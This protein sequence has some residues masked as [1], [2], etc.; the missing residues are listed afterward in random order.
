[1]GEVM[2]IIS[3]NCGS[4]SLKISLFDMTTYQVIV[5]FNFERI[6]ISNPFYTINMNNEKIKKEKNFNNHE[7]A[8]SI[9]LTELMGL[10]VLNSL[11]EIEGVGHRVVHGGDKYNNSII[12]DEKVLADIEKYIFLAP[13]HNPSNL[14]GIKAFKKFLPNIKSVAVFDT[15]FHQTLE[16]DAYLYPVPYEWYKEYGVRKYGFHGISHKYI[17]ERMIDITGNKDLK[18]ISCHLGNG[19]SIA[20]I[21]KGKCIDTSLGFTPNA[22]LMMG[23]RCGDID[24]SIIPY[25]M[26][27]TGKKLE[28]VIEDLNKKSG[29]L[30]VS[31]LSSDYR[32]IAEGV[33]DKHEGSIIAEKIFIRRVIAYVSYYNSLLNGADV[34]VF[35]AGIGENMCLI[36]EKIGAC[37]KTIGVNIDIEKNKARKKEALITSDES[38]IKGYVIP[39]NEEL[40]IAK[41]VISL[42]N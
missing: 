22:G 37:L 13:L 28:E 40:M 6:G 14:L 9:F 17:T 20:A 32:E 35:T 19:C 34:I 29:F 21:D 30:G 23:T 38:K 8:I 12:I 33:N 7:E 31:G 26:K 27:Q 36:R 39:T 18:I 15:S 4:S 42:L 11:D 24:Y 3:V 41:E 25:I 10:K 1:M 5:A 2:K 16:K